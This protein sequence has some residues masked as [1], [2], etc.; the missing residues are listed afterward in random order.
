MHMKGIMVP[1]LR[2]RAWHLWF[3]CIF[4]VGLMGW[5]TADVMSG[6]ALTQSAVYEE[7]P[8]TD[9]SRRTVDLREIISGGPPKDGIP[10]IDHPTFVSFHEAGRWLHPREP[11]ITLEVANEACAYP[12][13]IL[14]WHEIVNDRIAG[15]PVAVT[16]CSLCNAAVVFDR[17]VSGQ[18]LDFG[19]TGK[20]RLSDLVM[21]DRQTE[22]WWQQISGEGIVGRYAGTELRRLN[23][24]IVAYEDFKN[25][26]PRGKVLSRATG[27]ARPYGKNPYRGYDRVGDIP[28]LFDHPV[29]K[30]L[31]PMERV[32]SMQHNAVQRIY[33]FS[34][35]KH[36]PVIN[37]QLDDLPVV[38]FSRGGTLS[39]LDEAT[40]EGSRS[41]SSATAFIRR[42][43]GRVLRFEA[44]M[45]RLY[46]VEPG[47][48]WNLLGRSVAGP[49]AGARLM[50]ADS[51]VHFAFAWLAFNPDTE[52]YGADRKASAGG[53]GP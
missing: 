25:A 36:E 6:P 12:L 37:D 18:V 46:D 19:T 52:I 31:P 49:L 5:W 9:F 14:I 10:A 15:V 26:F 44:R 21:Y 38:I 42:L 23:A 20:L 28:F 16:F 22:S 13:Q 47:S 17:R 40:I 51:G 8:L 33:P 43:D 48:E 41:V 27:F 4:A 24:S 39:V 50:P 2:R 3:L 35:F 34:V 32:I 7:W 1:P 30:R 11:V 45:G 53:K 29:D